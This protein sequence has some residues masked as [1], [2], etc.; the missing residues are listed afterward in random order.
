MLL[1]GM[2]AWSQI[3]QSLQWIRGDRK[4][5]NHNINKYWLNI[6]KNS[7]EGRRTMML[8]WGNP[9]VGDSISGIYLLGGNILAAIERLKRTQY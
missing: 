3:S 9:G 2:H 1:L 4:E 7:L 5:T 8:E 6:P